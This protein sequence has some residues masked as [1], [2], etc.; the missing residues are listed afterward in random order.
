MGNEKPNP[1]CYTMGMLTPQEIIDSTQASK[2]L[3][4]LLLAPVRGFSSK[5]LARRLHL[6]ERTLAGV[7][8]KFLKESLI[9]QFSRERAKLYI[10][11]AK[12][13]LLPEIKK[14]LLRNQKA[15]ED[16]LFRA[17]TKLGEVRAAF[18]SGLFTGQPQLPVDLLLVGKISLTKLDNFLKQCKAM[19]GASINYS[20]MSA[21]E[22]R[23]RS[24]TFDRFIK[25]IFDYPHLVVVDKTKR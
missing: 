3:A 18:L 2:V 15:Y 5:E 8:R 11:N 23:L 22:F 24:D 9:K 19:L 17:I 20:I 25:D 4:F 7:L 14:S 1:V 10:L 21:E 6:T 16:E 13:P 12:H